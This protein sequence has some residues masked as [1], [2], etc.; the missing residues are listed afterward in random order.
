MSLSTLFHNGV[1]SQSTFFLPSD[2]PQGSSLRFRNTFYETALEPP[3]VRETCDQQSTSLTIVPEM[4]FKIHSVVDGV[5]RLN[6]V[7]DDAYFEYILRIIDGNIWL[8]HHRH[9]MDL[10][11]SVP[12]VVEVTD[13]RPSTDQEL[14][15]LTKRYQELENLKILKHYRDDDDVVESPLKKPNL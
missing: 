14:I 11:Y 9:P 3:P 13:D 6:I 15:D 8:C 7:L 4:V 12:V 10:T 1:Q 2:F 5:V